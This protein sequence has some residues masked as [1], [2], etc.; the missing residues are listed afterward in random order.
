MFGSSAKVYILRC[1]ELERQENEDAEEDEEGTE[2][3][4]LIKKQ[5]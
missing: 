1:P 4:K 2:F 3:Q 5:Y